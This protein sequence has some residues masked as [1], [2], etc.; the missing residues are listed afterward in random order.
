[1][2][3][4]TTKDETTTQTAAPVALPTYEIDGHGREVWRVGTL[5]YSLAGLV[6]LFFWLLWGDFSFFLKERSV[7]SV[8]Q[9]LL[10]KFNASNATAGFLVGS[11]PQLIAIFLSPIISYRSDRHRGRWGRRIPYLFIPTPIAFLSMVGLAYSPQLGAS[12]HKVLGSHSPGLDGCI[13]INLGL[14]WTLFEFCSIVCNSVLAAL[15][16]DVVPRQLIGRFFAL[17]RMFSLA[18]GVGFNWYL[19]GQVEKY[20]APIFIGIGA[21]YL[22]SFSMMCFFVKEGTYPPVE[23]LPPAGRGAH[24]A[25]GPVPGGF[26]PFGVIGTYFRE[27]F[28]HPYYRWYFLSIALAAMAFQPANLYTLFFAQ[29]A[30][31]GLE[32]LGKAYGIQL[33]ISFIVAFPLGWL[34]DKF[35]PFRVTIAATALY[36]LS[37]AVAFNLVHGPR[38]L[39]WAII[40]CGVMAGCWLTA[41]AILAPLVLPKARF[42]TLASAMGVCQSVGVMVVSWVSG[43][44]LDMLNGPIRA[45]QVHRHLDYQYIYAFCALMMTAALWATIVVYRKFMALGGPEG[46][47]APE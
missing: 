26:R 40:I 20:Y 41:T 46:Y 28:S 9:S 39:Y 10:G 32:G 25:A 1:M 17:F 7:P 45:G 27:C 30:G 44:L 14:Y 21:L 5:T 31:L 35:H 15:V 18:A 19:L 8:L 13:V 2:E 42:A 11:L 6:I 22:V 38:S 23:E 36:A 3:T 16:N 37:T 33:G 24:T 4:Q 43:K 12:L 47:V 29:S 34:A